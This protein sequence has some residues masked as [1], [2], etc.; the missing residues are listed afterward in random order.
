MAYFPN[1]ILEM[2]DVFDAMTDPDK[3]YR[4]PMSAEE[5]LAAM[6]KEYLDVPHPGL[7]PILFTIFVD[8]MQASGQ[9]DDPQ[10]AEQLRIGRR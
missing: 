3:K 2:L 5:A 6:R 10:S 4:K 1:K 7:D 9:L 8:F